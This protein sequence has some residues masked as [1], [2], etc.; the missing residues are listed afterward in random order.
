MT[1]SIL[2]RGKNQCHYRFFPGAIYLH[3][4]IFVIVDRWDS[5]GIIGVDRESVMSEI[6]ARSA[7][8][9]DHDT[10]P[11][12]PQDLSMEELKG[13][14]SRIFPL[15]F[16]CAVCKRVVHSLDNPANLVDRLAE[17]GRQ[18][19][20]MGHSFF[21][22]Q[23]RFVSVDPCGFV[24]EGFDPSQSYCRSHRAA[25][26][27]LVT[28]A[29]ERV[30]NFRWACTQPSCGTELR[31]NGISHACP[32]DAIRN[33]KTQATPPKDPRST[34]IQLITK[35]VVSLPEVFTRVNLQDS[36]RLDIKEYSNWKARVLTAVCSWENYVTPDLTTDIH[37]IR[38]DYGDRLLDALEEVARTRPE[39]AEQVR[40]NLPADLSSRSSGTGRQIPD[41]TANEMLDF[42]LAI[43]QPPSGLAR[44]LV[45]ENPELSIPLARMGIRDVVLLEELNLTT[46]LYGYSRG[47]Y[48]TRK[49]RLRL[50]AE[51]DERR[52]GHRSEWK[53]YCSPVNTEGVML[54][55]DPLKLYGFISDKLGE[56]MTSCENPTDLC[57]CAETIAMMYDHG[58]RQPVFGFRDS[59]SGSA[60]LYRIIHTMS[61]LFIRNLGRTTG[62]EE[63]SIAEMLFPSCSSV[64]LYAS[65]S[66]EFNLGTFSTCFENYLEELLAGVRER[67]DDC[68]YD[69]VCLQDLNGA[70]PACLLIGEVSCEN[71][72]RDLSR[73][74]LVGDGHVKGYWQ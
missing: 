37:A 32:S 35:N 17:A 20:A 13:V 15:V 42:L 10:L 25:P 67:A 5:Q 33:D 60:W 54:V 50:F 59:G 14:R 55:L 6:R 63:S 51:R 7:A 30:A 56:R 72:N 11:D 52:H 40:R 28:Y 24:G 66:G 47:E 62:V 29:S 58:E 38:G 27:N 45:R 1:G 48:L 3:D 46:V 19:Q 70:C 18:C 4:G 57:K 9:L 12:G 43:N 31:V 73:K 22:R 39:V 36:R 21:P 69:P 74:Y 41:R 53:I 65:Q 34:Q 71:F 61:H 44:S 16:V 8:F 2:R 26:L 64:L 23:F 68:L 49:R